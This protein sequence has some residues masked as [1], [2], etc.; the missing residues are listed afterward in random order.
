MTNSQEERNV[1]KDEMNRL[2]SLSQSEVNKVKLSK[3]RL[4]TVRTY[5]HL[6]ISGGKKAGRQIRT[7]SY[8][9]VG[10]PRSLISHL[11]QVLP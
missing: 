11:D 9:Q 3:T 1:R 8:R 10:K 6:L 5:V 2:K 7:Y 4:S